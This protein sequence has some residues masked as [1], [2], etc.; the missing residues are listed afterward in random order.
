MSERRVRRHGLQNDLLQGQRQG[1]DVPVGGAGSPKRGRGLSNRS[2]YGYRPVSIS[3]IVT[4]SPKTSA[5]A[6][7]GSPR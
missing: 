7:P 2:P 5:R 1:W 6:S 4:P 3:Y